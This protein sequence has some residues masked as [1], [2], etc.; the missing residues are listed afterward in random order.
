M[1]TTEVLSYLDHLEDNLDDLEESVNELL[2]S[3]SLA[4]A[5]KQLPLLDRAKLHV[6]VVYAI[7]SLLFCAQYLSSIYDSHA[8]V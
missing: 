2:P 7:E 1:N 6:T 5:S 3:D 8:D 4:E